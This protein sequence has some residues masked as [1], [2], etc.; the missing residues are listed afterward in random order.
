MKRA[1][2][3]LLI[4][5]LTLLG[6]SAALA[7]RFRLGGGYLGAVV[8]A[9]LLIASAILVSW[10]RH[11]AHPGFG[12]A[13]GVTLLRA[14]CVC[15]IAGTVVLDTILPQLVW[16]VAGIAACNLLLDGFDGRLAR[17]YSMSS[18][19]GARFDT[20]VDALMIL[21][22]CVVLVV[23]Y[24][25]G[26]WILAIGL[27]RYL[28]VAAGLLWPWLR[29]PLEGSIRGRAICSYQ[30]LA[31]ILALVP[32]VAAVRELLLVSALLLLIYSFTSDIRSLH[33]RATHALPAVS[34][35]I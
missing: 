15:L 10:P 31:L 16:I 23:Q 6:G 22:L 33:R 19:F 28:F 18:G 4:G 3:A 14:I 1:V 30:V 2:D 12:I 7:C 21:V 32:P 20:E 27:L 11:Q 5:L 34:C 13:N 9:Y 29:A 24:G 35:K 8:T 26:A 17:H 25:V